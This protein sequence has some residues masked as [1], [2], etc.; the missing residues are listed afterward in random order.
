MAKPGF[1][2]V[3]LL[4]VIVIIGILSALLVPALVEAIYKA[5]ETQCLNNLRE[6]GK[7]TQIYR[8]NFGRSNLPD[9]TGS[10]WHRQI[11]STVLREEEPEVFHCPLEAS[12]ATVPDYRGPARNI[13]SPRHYR[14]G[15]AIAGDKVFGAETNHGGAARRGVMALTQDHKVHAITLDDGVRWTRYLSDTSD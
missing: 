7:L 15:D 11:M 14:S 1:T 5:K 10:G 12:E 13:N 2:L 3:E 8:T 4:V 6:I 9:A